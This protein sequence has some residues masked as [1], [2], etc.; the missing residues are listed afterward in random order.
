MRDHT[1]LADRQ[2]KIEQVGRTTVRAADQSLSAYEKYMPQCPKI[3]VGQFFSVSQRW[4]GADF[5]V[6]VSVILLLRRAHSHTRTN[7]FG[8]V[9]AA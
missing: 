1:R 4:P 7:D 6:S 9:Q 5:K 8:S 3:A 2:R